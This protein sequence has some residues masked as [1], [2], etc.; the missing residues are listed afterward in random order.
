MILIGTACLLGALLAAGPASAHNWGCWKQ[1]NRTV[2]T[3]NTAALSSQANAAIQEWDSKTILSIPLVG[4][5][6]EVSVFDGY[7]GNTGWAGLASIESYSGCNI[8]HGHARVNRSYSYTS[9]GYRGIFCQEIGHLFGLDHSND[10]GCMGGGY[11]YS[12]DTYYT[13]VSH[14]VTDIS[15]KYAGVPL[16]PKE[17]LGPPRPEPGRTQAVAFWN[18]RPRTLH[19]AMTKSQAVVVATVTL[20]TPGPDIQVPSSAFAD[21]VDRIP[22]ERVFLAVE[23][24][25]RGEMKSTSFELFR[26]GN[27]KFVVDEEP[28]Y[29]AG[30]RWVL[31]VTQREDG[32]YRAIAPE[33]RMK[34][35]AKGLEPAAEGELLSEQRGRS[36]ESLSGELAQLASPE[37][38]GTA[39]LQFRRNV[40]Q[41]FTS[42]PSVSYALPRASDVKLAVFDVR[43]RFVRTLVDTHQDPNTWY[44]VEWDGTN[45]HRQPAANGV[46]YFRLQTQDG[47]RSLPVIRI[48]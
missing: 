24:V 3:Y 1:P 20:V 19:E 4:S 16:A 6:T 21:G 11:W 28:P 30:E 22:T 26:T 39:S 13:V 44:T 41:P 31:F 33:G 32:T 37:T 10:G 35:T 45:E 7:Y 34:V 48:D 12:I 46:Y 25:L 14:N 27:E 40:T 5:H 23:R 42:N 38:Q 8:L 43:G 29:A 47:M 15:N 36:L 9:N 18:D 17:G 2:Y